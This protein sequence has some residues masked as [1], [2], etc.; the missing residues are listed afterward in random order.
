MEK[1]ISEQ[2]NEKAQEIASQMTQENKRYDEIRNSGRVFTMFQTDDVIANQKEVVTAPLW[3]D[4]IA[5]LDSFYTNSLQTNDQKQYY[6]EIFQ[7]GSSLTNAQPQ[8]S[9][10]YGHK[11]G[12]G[13]YSGSNGLSTY[14]SKAIYA[15]YKQLLLDPG[16]TVFTFKGGVT[17]NQI[18]VVNINRA[19][20]K[21]RIDPGNVQLN[22]AELNG[23]SYAN[24]AFS[25]SVVGINASDK[26][27]QLIDDSGDT[28]ETVTS[29]VNSSRVYNIV[30]GTIDNGVYSGDTTG[31]GLFY[32]E[33]G[34]MVLNADVLDISCSFN[35]VTSSNKNGD[36]AYKLF[37]SISGSS[38]INSASYNFQGRSSETLTST[39]YFVRAKAPE[40]NF[41]NNPS[42]ATASTGNLSQP[43][44][45]GNPRTYITMVGLYNEKQEL[46]AVAKVSQPL[47]KSFNK[48]LVIKCK[49][50]Y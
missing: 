49:L 17:S 26:V 4:E 5:T 42:F 13:S 34:V 1:S 44:F 30:S 12:S 29:V 9:V 46:L 3:S 22:L 28:G 7:T 35:S 43:D 24:N 2:I 20:F 21:E 19:R 37:T 36:N 25:G 14:P 15:Q 23:D 11:L 8:F 40:Y 18:Y 47:L 45:V 16:Q 31:Y 48:E 50:D 10:A 27:I 6:Y 38:V 32:P 41:S 39:H 33:K